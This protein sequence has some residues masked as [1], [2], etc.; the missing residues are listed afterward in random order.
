MKRVILLRFHKDVHVVQNRIDIL[1]HFNP[2]IPIHGL[3]GGVENEFTLFKKSLKG[4]ESLH[5]LSITERDIKWRFSDWNI[6][7][8]FTEFGKNVDFDVLHTIEYDLLLLDKI[9]HIYPYK[10]EEK[11][12]YVTSLIELEQIKPLWNWYQKPQEYPV[13]EEKEFEKL[14]K[15]KY[16]IKVLYGSMAPGSTF[17]REFLEG[18]EK[19]SLPLIAHDEVRVPAIAQILG[20]DIKDTN[21]VPDWFDEVGPE[22]RLF[23]C[24]N[25]EVPMDELMAAYKSGRRKAFHPVYEVLS[26]NEL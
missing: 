19:L 24:D 3:F 15:E 21:F 6:L 13:E 17:T 25:F 23:N 16:H 10:K 4:L 20:I 2:A 18:Y 12:I 11:N 7:K 22:F 8:W 14:M 1:K 5:F 26:L 9:E